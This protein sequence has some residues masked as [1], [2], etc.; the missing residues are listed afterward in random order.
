M[1]IEGIFKKIISRL[2]KKRKEKRLSADFS[3]ETLETRRQW[4]D[5]LKVLKE[6]K[7]KKRMKRCSTSPTVREIMDNGIQ[8]ACVCMGHRCCYCLPYQLCYPLGLSITRRR[9]GEMTKGGNLECPVLLDTL[10]R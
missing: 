3:S 6:K 7:S 10:I 4:I 8:N 9:N 2:K 5:N 1:V